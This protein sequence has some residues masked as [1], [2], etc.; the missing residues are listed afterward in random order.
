MAVEKKVRV[1]A[2]IKSRFQQ[3]SA[4]SRLASD[5][6]MKCRMRTF[7]GYAICCGSRE[8]FVLRD[9]DKDGVDGASMHEHEHAD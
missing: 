1:I 4:D 9:R 6:N 3:S 2:A 5:I 8:C 7:Y